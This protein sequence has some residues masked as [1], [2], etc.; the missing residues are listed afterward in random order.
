MLSLHC[1][2]VLHW[3]GML[4]LLHT[5]FSWT[6]ESSLNFLFF[7]LVSLS[8]CQYSRGFYHIIYILTSP[9]FFFSNSHS[10][11]SI[12]ITNI[13]SLILGASLIVQLVKNSPAMQETQFDS[14][15]GKIHWR[16]DRLSTPVFLDFPCG[17]AGEEYTCSVGDLGSIPGLGRFLGE[18]KGYPLQYSL[19]RIPWTE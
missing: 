18:G 9:P 10:Y 19:W 6:N 1:P 8:V 4:T 17:S 3:Y 11:N 2:S 15:I 7:P 14:W 5:K 12:P 16:R 13:L